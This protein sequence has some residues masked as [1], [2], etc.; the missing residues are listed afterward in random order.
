MIKPFATVLL[1]VLFLTPALAR[2]EGRPYAPYYSLPTDAPFDGFARC[3]YAGRGRYD[4]Q[5]D[6]AAF[7]RYERRIH[8]P[9]D[10]S[11]RSK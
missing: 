3:D 4:C 11:N 9:A 5:D 1:L 2:N 8:G 10:R 7:R 6:E